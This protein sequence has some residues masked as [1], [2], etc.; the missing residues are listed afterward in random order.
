MAIQDESEELIEKAFN[1]S[2]YGV[3]LLINFSPNLQFSSLTQYDTESRELGANNKVRWT[4]DPLGDVFL[5]Y[6]HNLV[7]TP[8]DRWQFI[9]NQLPVKIQYALRF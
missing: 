5:V 9:S 3:R 1:E 8:D 6:N 4:F 2:L 7:R